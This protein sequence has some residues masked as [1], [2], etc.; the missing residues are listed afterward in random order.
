MED[1]G[2]TSERSPLGSASVD[3]VSGKT[4]MIVHLAVL[5]D[6]YFRR[7]TKIHENLESFVLVV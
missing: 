2:I 7:E 3:A 5:K 4:H 1:D 6:I